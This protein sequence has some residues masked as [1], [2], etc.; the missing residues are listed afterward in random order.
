MQFIDLVTIHIESGAG[1]NGCLSFRRERNEPKGGPDGGNGGNGGSVIA[2]C[3]QGLNTLVDFRFKQH[4]KAKRGRNGEGSN[5]TGPNG[6]DILLH[7]PSG[8]QILESDGTTLLVDLTEPGETVVLAQGGH[9]GRGN[10]FFKSS[11]N[12]APRRTEVGGEGVSASLILRLKLLAD[13]GLVGLPNAGKSTLLSVVS[14]ARPKI[15]DYPFTTLAPQLGVVMVDGVEFVMADLPGLIQGAHEGV[16][17]GDR[18]LGHA[19][20]C[21]VLIHLVDA[22]EDDLQASYVSIQDEIIAYGH[23]L[24]DKLIIPC[25]TKVDAIG[26]KA[27]EKLL[28][29]LIDVSGKKPLIISSATGEGVEELIRTVKA[30]LLKEK[31]S[32]KTIS[33]LPFDPLKR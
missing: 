24:I 30:S 16:G 20:R 15:A 26:K 27:R 23:G 3:I 29:E 18:F 33:S 4:F 12:R 7:V 1:G 6:D 9:G 22:T 14:G 25:L 5:R 11:T 32:E 28:N 31:E 2:E 17:L 13:V 10:V 8:T 21:K 19:E